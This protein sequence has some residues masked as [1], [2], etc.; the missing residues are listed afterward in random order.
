MINEKLEVKT[1]PIV[2]MHCASCA[3]I[4]ENKLKKIPGVT[5]AE[6]NYGSEQARL[7]IEAGKV[8]DKVL[9]DAVSN[10]GY[11]AV[12]EKDEDTE[13]V[14]EDLKLKEYQLLKTKV[15][16]AVALSILILFGSFPTIF[17]FT[18]AFLTNKYLLFV[19]AA[20]VQFWVGSIFYKTFWANLKSRVTSMET[21][22]VLGTSI[23]FFYSFLST[24]FPMLFERMG[25]PMTMYFDTSAVIITLILLGR[26]LEERAK[27]HTSDALKKLVGLQVKTA[28]VI[29]NGKETN[30]PI[31][32]LRIGDLVRIRPGEKIPTDG[33]I[34]EGATSIDESMMTGESIPVEKEVGDKVVGSTQNSLGSIIVK[35]TKVG[36]DT[37]LSRIIS[38]VA[39]AQSSKA[40]I[41]KLADKVS[42]YFVPGVLLIA[43][44]TF[45]FWLIQGNVGLAIG[46]SIAVLVVACP[47]AL[48][49]ATPTAIMVGVG[50]GAE[51]GILIKDAG[52]LER[53]YGVKNIVFDKTGT[54][55][56][57]KPV[58]TDISGGDRVLAISASLENN[59]EHPLAGA[60]VKKAHEGGMKLEKVTNFKAESGLGIRGTIG[61]HNYFLGKSSGRATMTLSENGEILGSITVADS[62][63]KE[64]RGVVGEIKSKKINVWMITGDNQRV[65]D[66]IS[67]RVGIDHVLAGVL[68]NEKAEKI[69]KLGIGTAFVGDG[70]NDAPALA[71]AD[72]G[73]AMSTGSDI[74][75]ESAGVTILGG[76][77]NKVVSAITLSKKVI[78]TIRQNLVWAFGYNALLIPLAAMNLLKPEYAAFAMA[79][80]SIS[81]VGNSL[82]L[83]KVRI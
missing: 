80:S 26:L 56:T 27:A 28:R 32:D 48:G 73:I 14:K 29:V 44:I 31:E 53:L 3:K 9:Q 22:I 51:E 78:S 76:N 70:V 39:E 15:V 71:S 55:T 33:I 25:I 62:L 12:I 47:C 8:N 64:S 18:P 79:A 65:A 59:S 40:D 24:F 17:F 13:R 41:Q 37:L 42:T 61:K 43:V 35:V 63:K 82:R 46:S 83:R 30:L 72:I 7:I 58:V 1:F 23:A 10:L 57:G 34:V 21:L 5:S 36:N 68:P 11:Q 4:I 74:A 77:L 67:H 52:S 19:L 49:L 75:I 66:A 38:M 50:R 69:Q 60:I 6:I 81:V 20:T 54:L 16:V 2:G 45:A